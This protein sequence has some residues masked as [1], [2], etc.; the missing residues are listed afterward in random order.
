MVVG[1]LLHDQI[2]R[3]PAG[4]GWP[5]GIVMGAALVLAAVL[6]NLV[7]SVRADE[8]IW[9]VVVLLSALA[10]HQVMRSATLGLMA[11]DIDERMTTSAMA[12]DMT[13]LVAAVALSTLLPVLGF[14]PPPVALGAALGVI[15]A[16]ALA[17]APFVAFDGSLTTVTLLSVTLWLGYAL[18]AAAVYRHWP[19]NE[20]TRTWMM[21][22]VLCLG[23]AKA[24]Q[25]PAETWVWAGVVGVAA[26]LAAAG[27]LLVCMYTVVRDDLMAHRRHIHALRTRLVAEEDHVRRDRSQQ[28]AMRNL[29]AGITMA[30]ELLEDDALEESTRRR[31]EHRIYLEAEQLCGLFEQRPP[32]ARRQAHLDSTTAPGRQ[33][34]GLAARTVA[35]PAGGAHVGFRPQS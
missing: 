6:A 16:A 7:R 28:H 18:V 35:R 22:A 8:E 23:I 9:P 2:Q 29:A 5:S 20:L 1:V 34:P 25:G 21:V 15:A 26:Q 12:V 30:A 13:V 10:A 19:W 31:L 14:R 11:S 4:L 17:T 27:M 3:A 32:P 33:T 24:A